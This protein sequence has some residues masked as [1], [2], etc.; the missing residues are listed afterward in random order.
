[1]K[2]TK[3]GFVYSIISNYVADFSVLVAIW[4]LCIAWPLYQV[5]IAGPTFF[6]AHNVGRTEILLFIFLISFAVPL[7]WALLTTFLS[8]L[9][10]L[11]RNIF[12]AIGVSLP[13]VLFLAMTFLYQPWSW[14]PEWGIWILGVLLMA[15]TILIMVLLTRWHPSRLGIMFGNAVALLFV[16]LFIFSPPMINF[17]FPKSSQMEVERIGEQ[18]IEGE[19]PNIV[20]LVFDEFSLIDMLDTKENINEKLFP[21][22]SRLSKESIWFPNAYAYSGSTEK[23]LT[24]IFTGYA[25][26]DKVMP[27]SEQYPS[28]IFSILSKNYNVHGFES[29]TNFSKERDGYNQRIFINDCWTIFRRVFLNEKI[30]KYIGTPEIGAKWAF[31]SNEETKKINDKYKGISKQIDDI[32]NLLEKNKNDRWGTPPFAIIAHLLIPHVPYEYS[33]NGVKHN[34]PY[35]IQYFSQSDRLGKRNI[36]Y[37]SSIHY[38]AYLQ[39]LSYVDKI[40]GKIL[41]L[42]DSTNTALII[43][44]DHGVCYIPKKS[45]RG[46]SQFVLN[47]P[48]FFKIPNINPQIRHDYVTNADI[49]P[50][51]FDLLGY[52]ADTNFVGHSVLSKSYPLKKI[53]K[54]HDVDAEVFSQDVVKA[55]TTIEEELMIDKNNFI[56]FIT[57]QDKKFDLVGK[58]VSDYAK[59]EES[60]HDIKMKTTTN[61][62][63][64]INKKA[65]LPLFINAEISSNVD[66]PI[67]A[68]L[69][70]KIWSVTQTFNDQIRTSNNMLEFI[71]Y[72]PPAAFVEGYNKMELFIPVQ[73]VGEIKLS[74][75]TTIE[76]AAFLSDN[77]LT[78]NYENKIFKIQDT[79]NLQGSLR[80]NLQ[81]YIDNGKLNNQGVLTLEGWAIDKKEVKG[82]EEVLLFLGDEAIA[83]SGLPRSRPD[84]A[85]HFNEPRYEQ[86]GFWIM[87]PNIS[88]KELSVARLFAVSDDVAKELSLPSSLYTKIL[89]NI[90]N[91]TFTKTGELDW[92]NKKYLFEPSYD[93]K[94]S[95]DIVQVNN[96]QLVIQGWVINFTEKKPAEEFLVFINDKIIASSTS[97]LPR[98]DL[99]K[100]YNHDAYLKSGFDIQIP[101]SNIEL[102]PES[103]NNVTVYGLSSGSYIQL[104]ASVKN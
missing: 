91:V 51:L 39:Q 85:K 96:N 17:F 72:F 23:V 15:L 71:G 43:T 99:V 104:I 79:E 16:G 94:G 67:V 53:L 24:A 86:S 49:F 80:G 97:Q 8:L 59:V 83:F 42:T 26:P 50:S 12:F 87:V 3:K 18:I 95:I 92:N 57:C 34:Y 89:T 101:L 11:L 7:F 46:N 27:T 22:F 103:D 29:V 1:M 19:K 33:Y 56:D 62:F 77:G 100:A 69:N 31:F 6:P 28:N 21:N 93:I 84:I 55:I 2:K 73:H 10:N 41:D 35:D 5:F 66:L 58:K 25:P 30:N 61:I 37:I 40:I 14:L 36:P 32:L 70:G 45:R 64:R 44:A 82:A 78:I 20:V 52:K 60:N 63:N 47:I 90:D 68:A 13:L 102:D 88:D 4:S 9:N 75:I 98:P 76:K 74:P 48:L 65:F 38:L 81:V 54:P